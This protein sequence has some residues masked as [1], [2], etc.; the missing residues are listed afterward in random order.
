MSQAPQAEEPGPALSRRAALREHL[1]ILF[2]DA[3]GYLHLA[4]GRAGKDGPKEWQ[5]AVF[6]Y[7][8]RLE[9]ALNFIKGSDEQGYDV[10]F[11]PYLG[12][13]NARTKGTSVARTFVH[14]DVDRTLTAGEVAELGGFIVWSGTPGR[15]HVY[16]P[17]TRSV[18][19]EEHERLC[20]G[21]IA[22]LGGDPSKHSDNDLLRPAGTTNYKDPT[23]PQPVRLEIPPGRRLRDPDELAEQ[24]GVEFPDVPE[25]YRTHG[26]GALGPTR[27]SYMSQEDGSRTVPSPSPGP[28][29][30]SP[31]AEDADRILSRLREPYRGM[32]R[33]GHQ[34]KYRTRSEA[35]WAVTLHAFQRNLTLD[36]FSAIALN[37]RYKMHL[38]YGAEGRKK[39][40]REWKK[41][42]RTA[43]ENGSPVSKKLE[44]TRRAAALAAFPGRTGASDYAVLHGILTHARTIGRMDLNVSVRDAAEWG[45]VSSATADRAIKRLVEQGWL[46]VLEP[47]DKVSMLAASYRIVYPP[48][49]AGP[50]SPPSDDLPEVPDLPMG[51]FW[52]KLGSAELQLYHQLLW[53]PM[54]EQELVE[55][56]G[57]GCQTVRTHLRKLS[58]DGLLTEGPGHVWSATTKDTGDL[59]AQYGWDGAL[60]DR[61]DR[62]AR[63]RAGW[64]LTVRPPVTP[65]WT[66]RSD[67]DSALT[68]GQR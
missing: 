67:P 9:L 44:E 19:L 63:E 66:P 58:A 46:Q 41:A 51:D 28:D 38:W 53:R 1:E 16:V 17:L 18:T 32:V 24:L 29:L 15:G 21:L 52:L 59:A 36:E 31:P 55:A 68:E 11:C 30:S 37:P 47:A 6:S 39:L 35:R 22:R 65:W 27:E 62:H 48:R 3:Q 14:V 4:R 43:A 26:E 20:R 64:D 57:R 33:Y 7:P 23:S 45:N 56:T 49:T 25:T 10:Y 34:R 61:R 60:Q 5:T 40:D 54:T 12:R 50:A 2:K 13:T 42:A 8:R